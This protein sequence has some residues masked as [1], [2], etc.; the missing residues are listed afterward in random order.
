MD[1]EPKDP[2]SPDKPKPR[3]AEIILAV[4]AMGGAAIG[5]ILGGV[6]GGIFGVKA[7]RAVLEPPVE[8]ATPPVRDLSPIAAQT[9]PVL[10][11]KPIALQPGWHEPRPKE[12]PQPTY[13]P[14]ILAMAITLLALGVVTSFWVS[15]V[16][17]ILFVLSLARWIGELRREH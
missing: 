3:I 16:G 17:L 2:M 5:A 13:N 15:G 14:V 9:T 11:L 7:T 1:T 6:L 4:A 12:L 8:D 10:E